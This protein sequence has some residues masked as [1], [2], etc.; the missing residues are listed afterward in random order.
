MLPI[1]NGFFKNSLLVIGISPL[2]PLCS[3]GLPPPCEQWIMWKIL[4][5][6]SCEDT[7]G[8]HPIV[9]A[10]ASILQDTSVGKA[11]QPTAAE[12]RCFQSNHVLKNLTPHKPRKSPRLWFPNTIPCSVSWITQISC[13]E[14]E[15]G[16][17]LYSEQL[18][19][20][21]CT[22]VIPQHPFSSAFLQKKKWKSVAQSHPTICNPL[23]YT[24]HGIL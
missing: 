21:L 16:F 11:K 23:D 9:D 5:G 17:I 4:G 8:L 12:N 22:L 1:S 24:V 19:G 3:L 7:C 14:A 10:A 6:V 2:L 18:Q 15:K 13:E 20:A